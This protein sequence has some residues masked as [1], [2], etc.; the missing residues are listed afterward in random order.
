MENLEDQVC[1][2]SIYLM[3]YIA[4]TVATTTTVY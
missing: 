2:L 4:T 1:P 3:S